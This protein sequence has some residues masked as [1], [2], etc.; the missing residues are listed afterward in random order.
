MQTFAIAA[1]SGQRRLD[2]A[3]DAGRGADGEPVRDG[4]KVVVGDVRL[5]AGL[6]F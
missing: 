1:L 6:L 5:L 3:Q 4:E 2:F